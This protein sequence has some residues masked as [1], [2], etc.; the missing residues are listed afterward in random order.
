MKLYAVSLLAFKDFKFD[1]NDC[2]YTAGV[3]YSHLATYFSAVNEDEANGKALRLCK[4]YF[5]EKDGWTTHKYS[6]MLIKLK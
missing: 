4:E 2:G 3:K 6:V 1:S 5:P